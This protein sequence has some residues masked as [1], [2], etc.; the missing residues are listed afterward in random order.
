MR[1]YFLGAS[2]VITSSERVAYWFAKRTSTLGRI[3]IYKGGLALRHIGLDS[4]GIMKRGEGEYT[5][6]FFFVSSPRLKHTTN[7]WLIFNQLWRNSAI[8]LKRISKQ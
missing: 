6:N 5:N 4:A 2:P 7:V 8:D 1:S 3:I